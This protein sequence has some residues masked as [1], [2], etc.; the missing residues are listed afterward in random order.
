MP[1]LSRIQ[2]RL[3]Q[4]PNNLFEIS[5]MKILFVLSLGMVCQHTPDNSSVPGFDLFFMKNFCISPKIIDIMF[6]IKSPCNF[7]FIWWP[8]IWENQKIELDLVTSC[9]RFWKFSVSEIFQNFLIAWT[10]FEPDL[11]VLSSVIYSCTDMYRLY[12]IVAD[13]LTRFYWSNYLWALLSGDFYSY[14]RDNAL[15]R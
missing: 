4:L 5:E 12:S 6:D 7:I 13:C 11:E 8:S 2:K 15:I 10:E 9:D 14:Q 3:E 1:W